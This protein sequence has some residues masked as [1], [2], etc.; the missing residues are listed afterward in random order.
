MH[1]SNF[2]LHSAFHVTLKDPAITDTC[3][4]KVDSATSEYFRI[5]M[6]K[7]VHLC[8][9]SHSGSKFMP[10]RVEGYELVVS[11]NAFKNIFYYL[12]LK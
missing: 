8:N 12:R 10:K 5:E 6:S 9:T 11:K 7:N 4:M 2:M 3:D 1:A